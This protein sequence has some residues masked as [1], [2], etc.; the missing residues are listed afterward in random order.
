MRKMEPDFSKP[1]WD[2]K[3]KLVEIGIVV[4]VLSFFTAYFVDGY[5]YHPIP[6]PKGTQLERSFFTF[7]LSQSNSEYADA[8]VLY[9][10]MDS[11]GDYIFMVKKDGE[12]HLLCYAMHYPTQRR[13]LVDDQIIAPGTT[14][15][16]KL[17]QGR[18]E[19]ENGEVT[20]SYARNTHFQEV[21]YGVSAM[22]AAG[23][24]FVTML[25]ASLVAKG[26]KKRETFD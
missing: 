9:Q 21:S 14:G 10:S 20:R 2:W 22:I 1:K 18:V 24:T 26:L 11:N 17:F 13:R 4:F 5:V 12:I 19:L 15:A 3:D 8:E 25:P 7:D 6:A 23:V 16:I